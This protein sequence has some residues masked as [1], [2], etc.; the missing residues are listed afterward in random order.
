MRSSIRLSPL[1]SL[2]P[3]AID[4]A[5]TERSPGVY[6]LDR[7]SQGSFTVT[8]VGRSDTEVNAALHAHV[9]GYRFFKYAYCSSAKDAF[10]AQCE[11]YHRHDPRDNPGHPMPGHLICLGG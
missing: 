2:M 7:S 1:Y 10:E 4:S 9:G 8:Y 6:V 3:S 5:V 11:L